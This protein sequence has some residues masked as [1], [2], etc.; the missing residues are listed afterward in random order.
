MSDARLKVFDS[1]DENVL[2]SNTKRKAFFGC[3]AR[4]IEHKS[5]SFKGLV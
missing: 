5:G 1:S 3:L 2:R 4:M